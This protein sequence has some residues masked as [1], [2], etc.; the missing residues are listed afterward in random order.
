MTNVQLWG[1]RVAAWRA[2]GLSSPEFCKG[3]DF[4][5]GRLRVWA[6]WLELLGTASARPSPGAIPLARVVVVPTAPSDPV[7]QTQ[8]QRAGDPGQT[9]HEATLVLEA[10][11]VRIALRPGFDRATLT[12]VLDVLDQRAPRPRRAS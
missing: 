10:Q 6:H 11:G 8:V 12:S 1:Q 2:S 4:T 9:P 3:K 5:A 7:A